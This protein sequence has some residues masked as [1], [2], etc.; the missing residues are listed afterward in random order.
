M[1]ELE[2]VIAENNQKCK[3]KMSNMIQLKQELDKAVADS[4]ASA[5]QISVLKMQTNSFLRVGFTTVSLDPENDRKR[6]LEKT[7]NTWPRNKTR[8]MTP[9]EIKDFLVIQLYPSWRRMLNRMSS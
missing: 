4:G 2:S 8:S 9:S 7:S 5:I 1:S 6:I 3:S